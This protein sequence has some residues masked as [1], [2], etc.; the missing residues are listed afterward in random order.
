MRIEVSH[1]NGAQYNAY[2][3]RYGK[4]EQIDAA[5]IVEERNAGT[6][7]GK[8]L[9]KCNTLERVR[10]R[11]SGNIVSFSSPQSANPQRA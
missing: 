11:V 8:C 7:V 10:L 1:I 9:E 4:E 6:I 3:P 5:G 2:I